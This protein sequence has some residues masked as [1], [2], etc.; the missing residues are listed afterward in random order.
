MKITTCP[1]CQG[2]G[3]TLE[4]GCQVVCS[5]CLGVGAVNVQPAVT[6]TSEEQTYMNA[7]KE[8]IPPGQASPL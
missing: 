3:R 1:T 4:L 2:N 6:T 5:T 8:N 7:L